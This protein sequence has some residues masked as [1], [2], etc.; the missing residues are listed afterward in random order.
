MKGTNTISS[1][2]DF[3]ERSSSK[4]EKETRKAAAR[5]SVK[6]KHLLVFS[7]LIAWCVSAYWLQS[8]LR[9]FTLTSS[10]II[11]LMMT[12]QKDRSRSQ[13]EL[14]KETNKKNI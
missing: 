10:L 7:V 3:S 2:I 1:R 13:I 4:S 5:R 6:L 8:E 12:M 9:H 14:I 11:L